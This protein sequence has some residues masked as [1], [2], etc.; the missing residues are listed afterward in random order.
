MLSCP[1]ATRLGHHPLK[2]LLIEKFGGAAGRA[3]IVQPIRL[4]IVSREERTVH[5]GGV[6]SLEEA[7]N[8]YLLALMFGDAQNLDFA[9]GAPKNRQSG[10][11]GAARFRLLLAI[12]TDDGRLS[13]KTE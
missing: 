2:V 3:K 13:Q 11:G 7:E 6:A 9:R 4:G 1:R 12:V 8:K 5:P 10:R